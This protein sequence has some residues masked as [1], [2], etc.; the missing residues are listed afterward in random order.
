MKEFIKARQISINELNK[1]D[2][3]TDCFII[4]NVFSKQKCDRVINFLKRFSSENKEN[5]RVAGQNWHYL[6]RSNNNFFDSYIFNSLASLDCFELKLMYR[7]LYELYNFF[8]GKTFVNDF[9][10]EIKIQDFTT[11]YKIIQPLCFWY[12][13]NKST[14]NWHKHDLLNQKFQLVTNLT[15]PGFDYKEGETLVYTG[16]GKPIND[17]SLNCEE[18]T[19]FGSNFEKGDVF[20]FPYGFWHKVKT[21]KTT[22]LG[23]DAR[24]SLLMPI[25]YRNNDIVK[26]E[27]I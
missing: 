9:D 1:V 25:G 18:V 11:N 17:N 13:N 10:K 4:K 20:S 19:E 15:Q 21:S 27:F 8:G 14:F 26:N 22:G 23:I 2:P 6:V 24:V 16:I 3:L 5:E 7:R 12:F